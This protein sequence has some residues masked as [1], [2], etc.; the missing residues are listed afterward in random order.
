MANQC[1]DLILGDLVM[2]A[3][4]RLRGV[5][6]EIINNSGGLSV[7][8]LTFASLALVIGI[9]IQVSLPNHILGPNEIEGDTLENSAHDL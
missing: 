4:P 2:P 7:L 3:N 8:S 1:I 9:G 6:I 5:I